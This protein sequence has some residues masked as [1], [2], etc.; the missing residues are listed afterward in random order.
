MKNLSLDEIKNTELNVLKVIDKI[1]DENN[2]KYSLFGG[3]AIG[4]VRH[5]GFI[6]WDDDIDIMILRKD[7]EKLLNIFQ[8][9]NNNI[10]NCMFMDATIQK[11]Y[12]YVWG[13]VVNLNTTAKE[14]GIRKIENY[15]VFVDIFPIDKIPE[16]IKERL[17]FYKRLR[18]RNQI[19]NLCI[20]DKQ[21]SNNKIKL[22]IKKFIA[23]FLAFIDLH[24][25][26]LKTIDLM[27]KYNHT[28]SKKYSMLHIRTAI[29]EKIVYD[30][31]ELA[32]IIKIPFE[33]TKISI[34]KE[35]DRML[36]K[37]FGNYMALPPIEE[38]KS[39]HNWEYIKYNNE[40][41]G[42]ENYDKK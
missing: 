26:V 18:R 38:R 35:Y 7:Y 40:I 36:K 22:Y 6:P 15:G 37:R 39:G 11:D 9:H 31:T 5:H 24:K 16:N 23:V 33:D 32:E 8:K 17:R 3:S 21:I 42:N 19:I 13:K 12:N 1:C 29:N 10:N 30:E 25:F 41:W 27:K 14:T 34:Y 28:N 2:I 4:G 20:Y